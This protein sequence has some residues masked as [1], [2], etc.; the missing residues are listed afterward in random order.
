MRQ[1][2]GIRFALEPALSTIAR[3]TLPLLRQD[4]LVERGKVAHFMPS[5]QSH[6]RWGEALR[7]TVALWFFVLLV[8][9]PIIIERHAGEP[10]IGIVLDSATVLVSI[11][12]AMSMFVAS[13]VT[14]GMTTLLLI[15]LGAVAF[16][17]AGWA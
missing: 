15:P 16:V 17:G 14:V 1:L 7:S 13:R 10:V 8:F 9:M 2:I 3:D 4:C 12:L 5:M 11:V 6:A